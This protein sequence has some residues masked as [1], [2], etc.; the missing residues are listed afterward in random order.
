MATT[1]LGLAGIP[2]SPYGSFAG[3]AE[4][5]PAADQIT[6]LGL[7]GFTRMMYGSFTGKAEATGSGRVVQG[8]KFMRSLGRGMS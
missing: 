7:S 5:V 4:A 8:K 3:K 6:R 1:R 2:R